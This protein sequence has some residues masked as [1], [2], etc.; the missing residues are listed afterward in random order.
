MPIRLDERLSKIASLVDF[1]KI[2]DV[3]CDHGKL[4]YYLVSTDKASKAIAMDIS[5]PSLNKAKELAK[6]NGAEDVMECRLSDGLDKLSSE[7]VDTIIIAGLGGDVISSIVLKAYEEGKKFSKYLLSSNTHP[8]KVR[9]ALQKIGQ[10]IIYDD[11]LECSGKVYSII[12]SE[13]GKMSLD[14]FQIKFGAFYKENDSFKIYG[15]KELSSL[16]NIYKQNSSSKE[17]LEKINYLKAALG[18]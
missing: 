1:G 13:N 5:L 16:E 7:E 14:D 2:A 15:K 18:E 12:K 8:E 11:L 10:N 3:G 6:D 17:L 4:S 9:E